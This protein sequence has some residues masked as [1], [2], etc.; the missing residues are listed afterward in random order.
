MSPDVAKLH[1]SVENSPF[2]LIWEPENNFEETEK[3]I[4]S[5]KI[6]FQMMGVNRFQSFQ[7]DFNQTS[8]MQRGLDLG[9]IKP[10]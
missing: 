4:N 10:V 9:Y 3:A 2:S 6:A 5:T 8:M 1:L 7:Y